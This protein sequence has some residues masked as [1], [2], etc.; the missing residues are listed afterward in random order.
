M[1]Q[2]VVFSNTTIFTYN[3]KQL[4]AEEGIVNK[5]ITKFTHSKCD[6]FD[7]ITMYGYTKV[8]EHSIVLLENKEVA[9]TGFVTI[10]V[11]SIQY[12]LLLKQ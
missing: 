5:A 3:F 7:F 10:T 8:I 9:N 4:E 2:K 12:V 6:P 1:N 11:L